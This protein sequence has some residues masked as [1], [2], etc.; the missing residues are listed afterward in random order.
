MFSASASVCGVVIPHVCLPMTIHLDT[1][2]VATHFDQVT[3]TCFYTIERDGK[4]W[5]AS[6][7]LADLNKL[8]A[9]KTAKHALVAN[10]LNVAM[11]GA[12]DV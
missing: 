12:P 10:K 7:P 3:Q 11:L 1:E 5:T 4:R 8:A 6:V 2:I 9:N